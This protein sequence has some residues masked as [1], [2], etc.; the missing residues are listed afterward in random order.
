MAGS[1]KSSRRSSG[2]RPHSHRLKSAAGPARRRRPWRGRAR[3]R[4][5]CRRG[6]PATRPRHQWHGGAPSR[7]PG[8]P[9]RRP[10]SGA[11][12]SRLSAMPSS[13][14]AGSSGPT[15]PVACSASTRSTTVSCAMRRCQNVAVGS[16]RLNVHTGRRRVDGAHGVEQGGQPGLIPAQRATVGR[17]RLL[18]RRRFG[19]PLPQDERDPVVSDPDVAEQLID[20][21]PRA[22][23]HLRRRVVTGGRGDARAP[24]VPRR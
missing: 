5:C 8:P 21:P 11:N 7:S 9:R 4:R 16:L 19:A 15:A 24:R 2:T 6:A 13:T 20:V 22:G 18:Q 3:L 1:P 10:M 12:T 17:A 14:S 23:R